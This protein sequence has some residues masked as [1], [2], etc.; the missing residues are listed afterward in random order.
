MIYSGST[1]EELLKE[2]DSK[3][4]LIESIYKLLEVITQSTDLSIIY[5]E[6]LSLAL[7]TIENADYGSLLIHDENNIYRFACLNGF[8]I[9]KFKDLKLRIEETSLYRETEGRMDKTCIVNEIFKYNS[10][11]F[12]NSDAEK[13]EEASGIDVKTTI[14][15]P[16]RIGGDVIAILNLDSKE[17]NAFDEKD[18]RNLEL[19]AMVT[20]NVI[21]INYLITN[22]DYINNH[23]ELT[24]VYNR[25]YFKQKIDEALLEGKPFQLAILDLDN[26]KT[27]ND[28]YGHIFGD[29]YLKV[30]AEHASKVVEKYGIFSRFGGDEFNI[31]VNEG[32]DKILEEISN[33]LDKVSTGL[34]YSIKYSGGVSSY[35]FDG[36][37]YDELLKTAD[38]RMYEEKYKKKNNL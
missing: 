6:L 3:N 8:D 24:G 2:I 13:F 11:F 16:I 21:R 18:K 34:D 26:L 7:S 4:E 28:N 33:E 15:V 17:K 23:D 10:N 31:I 35:P 19:F 29:H 12:K 36:S 30:F 5:N 27:I 25:R 14:S 32:M 1:N 9:E 22:Q 38:G 20:N 37:D